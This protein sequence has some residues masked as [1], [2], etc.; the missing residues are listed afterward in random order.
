MK[1][2]QEG[3][4]VKNKFSPMGEKRRKYESDIIS[5]KRYNNKLSTFQID[6]ELHQKV[7]EYCE[8]NNIKVKDF[9]T[10]LISESL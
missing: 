9:L 7:K 5:K 3:Y 8:K 2:I 10:K 4:D 1:Y 6:K